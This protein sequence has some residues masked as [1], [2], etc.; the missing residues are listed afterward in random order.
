VK[1]DV[2][3]AVA[4]ASGAG[5]VTD[6]R[7]GRLYLDLPATARAHLRALGIRKVEDTWVCTACE[8]ARFF[9]HRRDRWTTGRQAGFAVRM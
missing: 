4:S 9:S 7:G 3:L 2:A 6:R 8:R 1:E 5:A